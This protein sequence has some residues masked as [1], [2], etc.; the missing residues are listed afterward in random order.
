MVTKDIIQCRT[1]NMAIWLQSSLHMLNQSIILT[2]TA[3]ILIAILKATYFNWK[4]LW[5]M[6]SFEITVI[7]EFLTPWCHQICHAYTCLCFALP[8]RSVQTT[9]LIASLLN[10]LF[11]KSFDSYTYMRTWI[12]LTYPVTGYSAFT[13]GRLI[14]KLTYTQAMYVPIY[15]ELLSKTR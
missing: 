4:L 13:Q 8:E 9:A 12:V 11:R 7:C 1:Y 14:M 5:I 6:T 3:T 10:S 15:E 2:W